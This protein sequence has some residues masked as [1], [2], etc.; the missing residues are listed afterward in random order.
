[1]DPKP[2]AWS[3]H[4]PVCTSYRRSGGA[5]G[6]LNLGMNHVAGLRALG[7]AGSCRA[8]TPRAKAVIYIFLSGGLAQHESFDMKPNAPDT[9]SRRVQADRHAHPR[10]SDLRALAD[11][12]DR[13]DLWALVR[14]LAHGYPDHS[15]GHMLMLSGRSQLPVGFDRL[16]TQE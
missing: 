13:S 7:D 12:A 14:S 3:E 11:L 10:H 6:L 4:S 8:A 15:A 1:M 5:I 9:H 2:P 16:K